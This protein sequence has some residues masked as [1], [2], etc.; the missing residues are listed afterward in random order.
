MLDDAG[1]AAIGNVLR[2]AAPDAEVLLVGSYARGEA[3]DRSN[4]DLLVVEPLVT[5]GHH[6]IARLKRAFGRPVLAWIC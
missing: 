4:L 5:A 2:S 6:K 1:I 3:N